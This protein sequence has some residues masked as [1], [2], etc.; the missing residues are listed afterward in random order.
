M[1]HGVTWNAA[2]SS[3]SYSRIKTVRLPSWDGIRRYTSA[4][5]Q[6]GLQ[7]SDSSFVGSFGGILYSL[8]NQINLS[9][10]SELLTVAPLHIKLPSTDVR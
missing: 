7:V 4:L 8:C 3:A 5:S 6:R 2:L 1:E 9:D 10:N